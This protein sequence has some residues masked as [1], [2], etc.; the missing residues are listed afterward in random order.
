MSLLRWM[1]ALALL[2][3]ARPV[4]AQPRS[5]LLSTVVV[6]ASAPIF[7]LPDENRTPLRVAAAGTVLKVI[8]REG[9]WYN[10][11]FQDPQIGA[12]VGYIQAKFVRE[13][14]DP[15]L[16][17]LDLSVPA[18]QPAE[19]TTQR[20]QSDQTRA[21]QMQATARGFQRGLKQGTTE[22]QLASSFTGTNAGGDTVTAFQLDAIVEYFATPSLEF[23]VSASAIKVSSLDT[24]GSIGGLFAYN[25]PSDSPANGFFG[26]AAGTGFGY[27]ALTG[28]PFFVE[29]FGGVRAMVPGGGGALMI[30]PFY[31]RN[32]FHGGS[33]PVSDVNVFGV[34]VGV[35]IFF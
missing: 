33:V 6:N 35:S 13:A 29:V 27:P 7:V 16:E 34:S 23:G 20:Q 12:R 31:Q 1:T 17:P 14:P 18:A 2:L 15:R 28:N 21:D 24:T 8:G 30:R 10:V 19:T 26:A 11:E 3:I 25:V 9:N 22:L 32:F 5:A 4:S